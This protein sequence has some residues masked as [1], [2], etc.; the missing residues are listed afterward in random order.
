MGLRRRDTLAI[1]AALGFGTLLPRGLEACRLFPKTSTDR[2]DAYQNGARVGSQR[3]EFSRD[4]GRFVVTRE[5]RFS[6]RNGT[7]QNLS[8]S[9]RAR[10]VW[11]RGWLDAFSAATRH[12]K[13]KIEVEARSVERGILL[14]NTSESDVVL[15]V[16]GYVVPSSLW[17]RDARLVSRLIDLVDGRVKLVKVHYAGKDVLPRG[18]EVAIASHYRIR[19]ELARDVWYSEDCQLL[20]MVVPIDQAEPV[21]FELL[22]FIARSQRAGFRNLTSSRRSH[23]PTYKKYRSNTQ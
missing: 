18:G 20:R 23:T 19:G 8:F 22:P 11:Y 15:Q 6:Y 21:R 3:L 1:G 4:S 12:G 14:V 17:H 9:Q 5:L 2:Y 7:G 13:T 10:E 16:S